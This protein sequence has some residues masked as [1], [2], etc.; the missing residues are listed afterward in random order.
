MDSCGWCH[1]PP[2]SQTPAWQR[3]AGFLWC[4]AWNRCHAET[5][6]SLS[7]RT[8]LPFWWL[9]ARKG[10]HESA[11]PL[12]CTTEVN[13][14]STH[15]SGSYSGQPDQPPSSLRRRSRCR[16]PDRATV[17]PLFS[18][19]LSGIWRKYNAVSCGYRYNDSRRCRLLFGF[20][21]PSKH[22]PCYLCA[23][24]TFR[25]SFLWKAHL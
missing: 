9:F 20:R 23:F 19:A 14:V 15:V 16:L 13:W 24:Q 7:H 12:C 18:A 1:P 2:P 6:T 4:F 8:I 5:R 25:N 21:H 22:G 10:P 3:F 17:L 11:W